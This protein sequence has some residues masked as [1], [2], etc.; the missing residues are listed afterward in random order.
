MLADL[1]AFSCELNYKW[2]LVG[3]EYL[4]P[5]LIRDIIKVEK[6]SITCQS[7]VNL[8][9]TENPKSNSKSEV[10]HD[11][12]L[13]HQSNFCGWRLK[14]CQF[15]QLSLFP[16]CGF[17]CVTFPNTFPWSCWKDI[18][19]FRPQHVWGHSEGIFPWKFLQMFPRV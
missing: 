18:I 10:A 11:M 13:W 8:W 1:H 16:F 7:F 12:Y 19:S 9:E 14:F 17:L 15:K 6:G 4:Y 5:H 2:V 3:L